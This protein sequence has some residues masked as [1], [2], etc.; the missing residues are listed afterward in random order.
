MTLATAAGKAYVRPYLDSSVYIAAIKGSTTEDS[1]R[2]KVSAQVLTEAQV[3]RVRIIAS[4]FLHAE[5][6]RDRG[7]DKPLDPTKELVVDNFLQ[8]SF[9][10]WVELDIA[11]ARDARTIVRRFGLKPPDAVHLAAAVRGKADIFFTWDERVIVATGGDP[12]QGAPGNVDGLLVTTPYV[13]QA[14]QQPLDLFGVTTGLAS[15]SWAPLGLPPASEAPVPPAADT[16]AESV[17]EA[18]STGET[19][20]DELSATEEG[21]VADGNLVQ[22]TDDAPDTL[23]QGE[24]AGEADTGDFDEP[25]DDASTTTGQRGPG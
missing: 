7:E 22:P 9:I 4:A 13:F 19:E 20:S 15:G 1:Q 6:I 2:V 17:D 8:R 25:T 24:T 5:V 11:G 23:A 12:Q 14:A 18:Q 21:G 10:S 3:G 16:P